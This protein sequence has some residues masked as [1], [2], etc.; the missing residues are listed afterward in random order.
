MIMYRGLSMQLLFSLEGGRR[1]S[2]IYILLGV[3]VLAG[4][5]L[6]LGR[7]VKFSIFGLASFEAKGKGRGTRRK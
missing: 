1:E 2:M 7:D 3:V 4:F 5:A 6:F